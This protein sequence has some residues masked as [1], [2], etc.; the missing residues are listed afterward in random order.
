MVKRKELAK[1]EKKK[2][3]KDKKKAKEIANEVSP[4]YIDFNS[5]KKLFLQILFFTNNV[6]NIN[7]TSWEITA[8]LY[9]YC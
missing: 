3:K 8:F 1:E 5:I 4:I 2:L 7:S 9:L 6:N